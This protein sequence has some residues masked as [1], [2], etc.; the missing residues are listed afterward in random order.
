MIILKMMYKGNVVIKS[1]LY[2]I[3]ILLFVLFFLSNLK[4]IVVKCKF[5]VL[6]VVCG[7]VIVFFFKEKRNLIEKKIDCF[8]VFKF[9]FKVLIFNRIFY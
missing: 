3:W 4:G 7:I 1:Y 6:N 5:V 2:G 8:F 9:S